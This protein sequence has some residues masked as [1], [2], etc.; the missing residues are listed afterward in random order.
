MRHSFNNAW[1]SQSGADYVNEAVSR[2]LTIG[3]DG[4]PLRVLPS[5]VKIGT[6]LQRVIRSLI[7]NHYRSPASLSRGK[8]HSLPKDKEDEDE[9][10][11]SVENHSDSFWDGEPTYRLKVEAGHQLDAGK[12]VRDFVT[13]AK[14][15]K[16]VHGMLTLLLEEDLDE[17]A[18]EVARRLGITVAE[19]YTARKRQA[20][21]I[22]NY[23]EKGARNDN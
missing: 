18:E 13:F 19:V 11:I 6:A 20:R 8:A 16:V 15:D 10:E 9:A 7:T 4:E 17:P 3:D 23:L 21:L 22:Q 14:S 2:C 12:S 1:V 5:R